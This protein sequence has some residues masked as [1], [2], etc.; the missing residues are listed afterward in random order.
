MHIN[1]NCPIQFNNL[2]RKQN[3]TKCLFSV[4]SPSF[5]SSVQ[6]SPLSPDNGP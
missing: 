2:T 4:S 6:T 3:K 1:D 5:T